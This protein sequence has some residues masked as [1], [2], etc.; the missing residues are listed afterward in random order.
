[1]F[2]S[3]PVNV[4][5][6]AQPSVDPS[7]G[8]PQGYWFQQQIDFPEAF[9]ASVCDY[10]TLWAAVIQAVSNPPQ[11]ISPA[12]FAIFNIIMRNG[13]VNSDT[14]YAMTLFGFMVAAEAVANRRIDFDGQV[15]RLGN[16]MAGLMCG[17][18]AMLQAAERDAYMVNNYGNFVSKMANNFQRALSDTQEIERY[19]RNAMMQYDQTGR[20]PPSA[21]YRL[22]G[23]PQGNSGGPGPLA[24]GR[25]GPLTGATA[26]R[27]PMVSAAQASTMASV[28]PVKEASA[29]GGR[30]SNAVELPPVKP[31]A[32]P[33]TPVPAL[34]A[35]SVGKAPDTRISTLSNSELERRKAILNS[36]ERMEAEALS[37]GKF[38]YANKRV[39]SWN[40]E[41][42]WH[43]SEKPVIPTNDLLLHQLVHYPLHEDLYYYDIGGGEFMPLRIPRR[44][45][46]TPEQI[47]TMNPCDIFG[48]AGP[49]AMSNVT[50]NALL[51]AIECVTPKTTV[52]DDPTAP[53]QPPI[54]EGH[55]VMI[56]S[57]PQIV[58]SLRDGW[59]AIDSKILSAVALDDVEA[60]ILL[61]VM[62]THIYYSFTG[63][64]DELKT[65]AAFNTLEA[66]HTHLLSMI[67]RKVDASLINL[68]AQ[69]AADA[70]NRYLRSHLGLS[71]VSI[72]DYLDP[73]C[74]G[75]FMRYM[76]E[77]KAAFYPAFA[78]AQRRII[79]QIMNF[80]TDRDWICGIID[81]SS[82]VDVDV[83]LIR[84]FAGDVVCFNDMYWLGRCQVSIADLGVSIFNQKVDQHQPYGLS[85][86]STVH[87]GVSEQNAAVYQLLDRTLK[88]ADTGGLPKMPLVLKLNDGVMMEVCRSEMDPK[89]GTIII[90]RF[91]E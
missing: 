19:G 9:I 53:D 24:A 84:K 62:R 30:W 71:K 12:R 86:S 16:V 4:F 34:Q 65:L 8:C 44:N 10:N 81:S 63:F 5:E 40:V 52:P 35:P 64:V 90:K 55:I 23:L 89:D 6:W 67:T 41:C 76:A 21:G 59:L 31:L 51:R 85:V 32:Q 36:L 38:L 57:T 58:S 73:T 39:A 46:L 80:I 3:E 61:P 20:Q 74:G 48:A 27:A 70:I 78:E 7:S 56:T 79:S 72:N 77:K 29:P 25:A 37:R 26:S 15:T 47:E 45:T 1:M 91:V 75:T 42:M 69:R 43:W 50:R 22:G 11:N 60:V 83:D 14:V 18:E 2:S 82:P 33:Q 17:S 68:I 88:Y 66:F 54:G 49:A 13:T 28:A 87:D